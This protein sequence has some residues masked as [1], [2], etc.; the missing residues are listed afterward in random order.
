MLDDAAASRVLTT[1]NLANA[2]AIPL[3]NHGGFSGARLWRVESET[4]PLCLRAWPPYDPT[5]ERLDWIHHLMFIASQAGLSFVPALVGTHKGQTWVQ[6]EGRLWDLCRWLP[7]QGD[8]RAHPSTA[9]IEAACTALAQLHS[10]WFEIGVT[11]GRCP[12]IER[13]LHAHREWLQWSQ[14]LNQL[15][16]ISAPPEIADLS[17]RAWLTAKRQMERVPKVVWQFFG[18]Q[19]QLQPCL[20]DIW[21]AHVLFQGEAVSGIVD[22]GGAKIDNVAVDLARLLGSMAG[23][24]KSLRAA[25]IEGYRK[26]RILTPHEEN[27]VWILDETGIIIALAT[28]LKWLYRDRRKFDNPQAVIARMSELL[29]RVEGQTC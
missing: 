29:E 27:L 18:T 10:S 25:G 4:G 13:R 15:P 14:N 1:Y 16:A 17:N 5:P 26:F 12:A 2:S 22:Y 21:H 23:N 28:W 19:V 9:R 20:C 11:S 8:F 24:D 3:G 6:S 7:G